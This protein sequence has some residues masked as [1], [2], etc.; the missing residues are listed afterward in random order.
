M[1]EDSHGKYKI[2]TPNDWADFWRYA[3]GVNVFPTDTQFR[4]DYAVRWSEWQDKPIPKEQHEK[5]KKGNAF[6]KGI[7]ILP[8]KIWFRED[9]KDLYLVF[10]DLDNQRAIDEFCSICG[11]V[12]LQELSKVVMVEQHK[13]DPKRA[14]IYFY[15]T[16]VFKKKSSDVNKYKK[17]IDDNK[18]PAIEV[19][20]LGSHGI[21]F[22]TNSKHKNGHRY[23]IIGT[24][25]PQTF[26]E[27]IENKLFETFQKY[28]LNIEKNGK[29]PIEKLF[30]DDFVVFEGHNRHEAI[31]RVIESLIHINIYIL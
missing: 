4:L 29:I 6:E 31:F 21:A 14:H 12:N 9:K 11:V 2:E 7:A 5:W 8:G 18:I 26:G 27:E 17:E 16:H 22:C 20:G 30:E 13:D 28:S 10:I 25:E 1:K 3:I 15:S 24:S 23:T 19:K